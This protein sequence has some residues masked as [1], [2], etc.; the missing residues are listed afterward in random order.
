MNG[1]A[2]IVFF[3]IKDAF[4]GQRG[5]NGIKILGRQIRVQFSAEKSD[6]TKHLEGEHVPAKNKRKHKQ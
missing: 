5:M 6:A 3:N 1:Q 4:N 2:W